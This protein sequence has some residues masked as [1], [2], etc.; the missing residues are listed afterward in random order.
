MRRPSKR[1]CHTHLLMECIDFKVFRVS[2]ELHSLK[3]GQTYKPKSL[4]HESCSVCV[5]FNL[6]FIIS[7]NHRRCKSIF[8]NL[9]SEYERALKH[10]ICSHTRVSFF[11]CGT[12]SLH[13]CVCVVPWKNWNIESL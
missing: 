6:S 9:V 5:Q 4:H 1:K 12:H 10:R 7:L 3:M 8:R 13:V 11:I 2:I